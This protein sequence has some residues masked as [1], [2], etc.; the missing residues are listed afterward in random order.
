ML[1]QFQH[2]YKYRIQFSSDTKTGYVN[3]TTVGSKNDAINLF[4]KHCRLQHPVV[5]DCKFLSIVVDKGGGGQIGTLTFEVNDEVV[6][7]FSGEDKVIDIEVPTKTSQLIN[8]SSFITRDDQIYGTNSRGPVVRDN[9]GNEV[10]KLSESG[11]LQIDYPENERPAIQINSDTVKV[12]D[13]GGDVRIEVNEAGVRLKA[14][15]ND[16]DWGEYSDIS[17]PEITL[18]K[19]NAGGVTIK[20]GSDTNFVLKPNLAL[21]N[22]HSNGLGYKY[23]TDIHDQTL[24]IDLGSEPVIK[25]VTRLENDGVVDREENVS[26]KTPNTVRGG[27][28]NIMQA[29]G[30][31]YILYHPGGTAQMLHSNPSGTDKDGNVTGKVFFLD[32]YHDGGNRLLEVTDEGDRTQ[33]QNESHTVNLKRPGTGDDD[34]LCINNFYDQSSGT[35]THKLEMLVGGNTTLWA[36]RQDGPSGSDATTRVQVEGND[37]VY[38]SYRHDGDGNDIERYVLITAAG[39]HDVLRGTFTSDPNT[40]DIVRETQVMTDGTSILRG[41]ENLPTSGN[42]VYTTTLQN[43]EGSEVLRAE[44][45]DGNNQ[46]VSVSMEN[47]GEGQLLDASHDLDD[48]DTH[49]NLMNHGNDV[50]ASYSRNWADRGVTL[51]NNGDDVIRAQVR[52]QNIGGTLYEQSE[53]WMNASGSNQILSANATVQDTTGKVSYDVYW[54]NNGDDILKAHMKD[55][56]DLYVELDNHGNPVVTNTYSYSFSNNRLDCVLNIQNADSDLTVLRSEYMRDSLSEDHQVTLSNAGKNHAANDDNL[57][58]NTHRLSDIV[59]GRQKTLYTSQELDSAT[60]GVFDLQTVDAQGNETIYT[61]LITT[62]KKTGGNMVHSSGIGV[63]YLENLNTSMECRIIIYNGNT[64]G[65]F[66]VDILPQ[67]NG[68]NYMIEAGEAV[69]LRLTVYRG[70]TGQQRVLKSEPRRMVF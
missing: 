39:E 34:G 10:L 7:T 35:E 44:K 56:D 33:G 32:S 38:G 19:D 66:S 27:H 61:T 52:T 18:N 37:L 26:V 59:L 14:A 20:G 43:P 31:R 17:E 25:A 41:R 11:L 6:G 15:P 4:L 51:Y 67:V 24:Q 36:E 45:R 3:V 23:G 40:G 42:N 22:S 54:Q 28:E 63:P 62:V 68:Q 70:S 9:D 58:L 53:M 50:L 69:E 60:D 8:D 21:L 29:N 64:S 65:A 5:I 16:Y 30:R 57:L 48:E 1:D 2:L 13:T 46:T 47:N 55:G 12:K 49:M